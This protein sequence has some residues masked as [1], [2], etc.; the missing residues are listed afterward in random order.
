MTR[1]QAMRLAVA[2]GEQMAENN[3]GLA[4]VQRAAWTRFI[5]HVW[6]GPA[7]RP[8]EST[9]RSG[10]TLPRSTSPCQAS[11]IELARDNGM[12][13]LETERS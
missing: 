10:E 4:A 3:P 9:N 1:D 7:V 8:S 12:P 6:G 13:V 2:A 11:G 5:R